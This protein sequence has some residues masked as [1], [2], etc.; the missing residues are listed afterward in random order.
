[1]L[2]GRESHLVKFHGDLVTR[3]L[4]PEANEGFEEFFQRVVLRTEAIGD[5]SQYCLMSEGRLIESMSDVKEIDDDSVI[6]VVFTNVAF[7]RRE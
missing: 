5:P 2:S 3:K 4:K 1:M 7:A 6:I